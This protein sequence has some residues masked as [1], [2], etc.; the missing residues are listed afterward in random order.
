VVLMPGPRPQ[1]DVTPFMASYEPPGPSTL[2][3]PIPAP[4]SQTS[5]PTSTLIVTNPHPM[6]R[7]G[8]SAGELSYRSHSASDNSW[9]TVPSN[10]GAVRKQREP[11]NHP[12]VGQVIHEDSGVRFPPQH[13]VLDIPPE[14]SPI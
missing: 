10:T 4:E 8:P 9:G 1:P 3:L 5:Y 6:H 2:R 12:P 7:H 11:V 14:Y 13:G